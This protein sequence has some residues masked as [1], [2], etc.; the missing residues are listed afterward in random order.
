MIETVHTHQL[1]N[2]SPVTDF[3]AHDPK[4]RRERCSERIAM[5]FGRA[6]ASRGG[7][8]INS[9][10]ER[11]PPRMKNVLFPRGFVDPRAR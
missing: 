6:K 7:A 3:L 9:D 1:K 11:S 5:M 2:A 10:G 8:S 4:D